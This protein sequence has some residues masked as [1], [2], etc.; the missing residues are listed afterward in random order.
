MAFKSNLPRTIETSSTAGA[1]TYS[2]GGAIAGAQAISANLSTGDTSHFTASD[3]TNW[4]NFLGT[5]TSGTPNTLA[6]TTIYHSSN[7]GSAVNWV[8]AGPR[9]IMANYLAEFGVV[10]TPT[11]TILANGFTPTAGDFL[12]GNGTELVMSGLIVPSGATIPASPTNGQLFLHT[13]T[14][15]SILYEY[16]GTSSTWM[17]LAAYG[18]TIIYCD[19][20]SGTDTINNGGSSGS[21]AFKTWAFSLAQL[22]KQLNVDVSINVNGTD[23]G[24][25]VVA[26][27]T[28]TGSINIQATLNFVGTLTVSAGTVGIGA[29]KGSVTRSSGLTLTLN[30][31]Q[32]L[33]LKGTSGSNNGAFFVI[34]SNTAGAA[35]VVTIV[36]QLSGSVVG[37]DTFDVYSCT[38]GR[39]G[40]TIVRNNTISVSINN[41]SLTGSV[42][43]TNCWVSV[44]FGTCN[45]TVSSGTGIAITVTDAAVSINQ[46]YINGSTISLNAS[47]SQ[48]V[49]TDSKIETDFGDAIYGSDYT[50]AIVNSSVINSMNA[51]NGTGVTA[52]RNSAVYLKVSGTNVFVTNFSTGILCSEE[53]FVDIGGGSPSVT[54]AGN[55]ANTSPV[56]AAGVNP[57][58]GI[59]TGVSAASYGSASQVAT[60]TVGADGRLTGAATTTIAIVPSQV[61]GLLAGM[62]P[63]GFALSYLSASTVGVATG[64]TPDK[65]SAALL[66]LSSAATLSTATV[67]AINGSDAKTITGTVATNTGNANVTGTTTTFTTAFGVRACTGT[68]ASSGTAVTGTTTKFLSQVKVNDLI[69]NVTRGYSRVTAV[70]SDTAL[71]LAA[72]LPNSA[73]S[74][75]AFNA[76]ENAWFQAGAQTIQQINTITD[77]THLALAANS[78][79]TAS[80]LSAQI[81]VLPS[82]QCGLHVWIGNG[83][84]GTGAFFSTQRT[85]PYGITGYNT[86]FRRVGSFVYDPATPTILPFEQEG[87]GIDRKYS[88]AFAGSSHSSSQTGLNA[89]SFTRIVWSALVPPTATGLQCRIVNSQ[90]TNLCL[91]SLRPANIGLG[92]DTTCNYTGGAVQTPTSS[93]IFANIG[94]DG[95][96]GL[97]YCFN[98]A[99]GNTPGQ[100]QIA[101]YTESLLT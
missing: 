63:V 32:N 81:G 15:R 70:A 64:W 62:S 60:F 80:G 9:W 53:S 43:V 92:G 7:G 97:E 24:S 27:F 19:F 10:V 30:S 47:G 85:T 11:G 76:I 22:P 52:T 50:S 101:G 98:T 29:T 17:P 90:P 45:C 79:G 67:G 89:T 75:D 4:E 77:D 36:N 37:G 46:C 91:I 33:I 6:R 21:G 78:S 93:V 34:D 1:G 41:V 16:D 44:V 71:T 25:A 82:S 83:G 35:G 38:S 73:A 26:G 14:G 96:Q 28:G 5:F 12:V 74:G 39:S 99:P 66:N 69:G 49:V 23:T 57:S 84:T 100:V 68:I 51:G 94:C 42:Q 31:V 88:F 2:L 61:T 58:Y 87:Q 72:A 8:G 3:G 56:V 54:F 48:P 55:S 59:D 20:A 95:G 18:T 40:V 86:Y 13:P 65:T